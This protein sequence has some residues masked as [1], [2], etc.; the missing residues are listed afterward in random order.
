MNLLAV[1]PHVIF[2]L[3]RLIAQWTD[4]AVILLLIFLCT[5]KRASVKIV[6]LLFPL[7]FFLPD[8]VPDRTLHLDTISEFREEVPQVILRLRRDSNRAEKFD[9]VLGKVALGVDQIDVVQLQ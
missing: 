3:E 6:Q 1:P 9:K 8:T 2:L 7:E 4:D 5:S